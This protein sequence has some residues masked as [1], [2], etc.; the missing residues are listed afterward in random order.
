MVVGDEFE[1]YLPSGLAFGES[2]RGAK[3]G[4]GYAIIFR[5]EL[6]KIKGQRIRATKRIAEAAA[7]AAAAV[8]GD[9]VGIEG[10][11]VNHTANAVCTAA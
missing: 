4:A 8:T 6:L 5:T 7:A 9:M 2:R 11:S 10:V 1:F 3:I